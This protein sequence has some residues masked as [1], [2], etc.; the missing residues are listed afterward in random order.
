[1]SVHVPDLM[2]FQ[3]LCNMM[4]LGNLCSLGA[5]LERPY[6][7]GQILEEELQ[8]CWV[9]HWHYLQLCLWFSKNH[10]IKVEGRF[11]AP[12]SIFQR[13]LVEFMAAVVTE[14]KMAE[15]DAPVIPG[16]S[17]DDILRCLETFI[18]AEDEDLLKPFK[19]LM[20]QGHHYLDWSSGQFEIETRHP[21]DAVV[22]SLNFTDFI[23]LADPVS[24]HIGGKA[25]SSHTVPTPV[26]GKRKLCFDGESLEDE[27]HSKK[28]S[29]RAHG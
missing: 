19:T 6:Y 26:V 16:C 4:A 15:E 2:T 1:M 27:E 11:V 24:A 20:E 14:K 23:L 22:E 8:E 9:A 12:K 5:I 28:R 7:T 3:G 17:S 18:M 10:T 13:S 29:R 21:D 25:S